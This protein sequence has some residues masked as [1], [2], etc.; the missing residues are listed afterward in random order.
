M[1]TL[2]ILLSTAGLAGAGAIA[3]ASPAQAVELANCPGARPISSAQIFRDGKPPGWGDI[4]LMRDNCSQYWAEVSM[5]AKLPKYA[6]TTAILVQTGGT[7]NGRTLTCDSGGGTGAVV[8]GQRTCRTP[9]V[10]SG[11]TST[12]FTAIAREYRNFGSGWDKIS[13]N[14]TARTR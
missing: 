8:A 5:D 1:K 11:D 14:R 6:M 10:K 2:G 7:N 3:L 12:T 9:K 4:K 13:E